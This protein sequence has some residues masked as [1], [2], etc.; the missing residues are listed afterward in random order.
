MKPYKIQEKMYKAPDPKI[1]TSTRDVVFNTLVCP[2]TIFW[3]GI[4]YELRRWFLPIAHRVILTSLSYSHHNPNSAIK[5]VS[6]EEQRQRY[7]AIKRGEFDSALLPSHYRNS[8]VADALS[9]VTLEEF[10]IQTHDG[11]ILNTLEIKPK[12]LHEDKYIVVMSGAGY[13]FEMT[14]GHHEGELSFIDFVH[15]AIAAKQTLINWNYRG[16]GYS[17][18]KF[19]ELMH[20]VVDGIAQVQRLLDQGI[21]N[22]NITLYGHSKGGSVAIYVADYFWQKGIPLKVITDRAYHSMTRMASVKGPFVKIPHKM[23]RLILKVL[24]IYLNPAKTVH[25]IPE[26]L[27]LHFFLGKDLDTTVPYFA[28]LNKDNSQ[29][30]GIELI[31]IRAK[32]NQHSVPHPEFM[33]NYEGKNITA[34]DAIAEFCNKDLSPIPPHNGHKKQVN[35]HWK[36]WVLYSILNAA[37]GIVLS[38]LF[39]KT[40]YS[41]FL[42]L[43]AGLAYTGI[44][45][46]I[47]LLWLLAIYPL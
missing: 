9:N 40:T 33:V 42:G 31:P 6:H 22:K 21:L 25:N 16:V 13:I 29:I 34:L 19:T 10:D 39:F 5:N 30:N 14:E 3:F 37:T 47:S 1:T 46:L 28:S 24:R 32:E 23:T 4:S 12:I 36:Q 41:L 11:A 44:W 45:F 8:A 20:L 2:I 43:G 17:K 18:K 26:S 27:R 38:S 15:I 35:D 7:D